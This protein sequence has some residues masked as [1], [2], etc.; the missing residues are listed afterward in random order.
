MEKPRWNPLEDE[1]F[2]KKLMKLSP[3][4]R[5]TVEQRIKEG[6][7]ELR[8]SQREE[9]RLMRMP[10]EQRLKEIYGNYLKLAF[11]DGCELGGRQL[12]DETKKDFKT[13]LRAGLTSRLRRFKVL[14]LE[15]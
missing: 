11:D 1:K 5:M 14:P 2:K 4:A 12:S 13:R 8:K 9:E 7:K 3:Y 6:N 10:K 15:G